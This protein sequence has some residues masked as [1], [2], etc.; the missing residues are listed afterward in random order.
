MHDADDRRQ[1]RVRTVL[2]MPRFTLL[3]TGL[4]ARGAAE[5][6]RA[7]LTTAHAINVQA[8]A[9]ARRVNRFGPAGAPL[10]PAADARVA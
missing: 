9:V 1:H 3:L 6:A 10:A 2:R 7:E 8:A 4:G 5:N